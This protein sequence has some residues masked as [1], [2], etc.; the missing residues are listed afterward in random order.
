[1][2]RKFAVYLFVGTI[3]ATSTAGAI[4]VCGQT[5]AYRL[6]NNPPGILSGQ[7]MPAGGIPPGLHT[8]TTTLGMQ[9]CQ[10]SQ[11]QALPFNPTP[12]CQAANTTMLSF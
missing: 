9:A 6:S 5:G 4:R 11:W 3:L 2:K 1:M 8:P 10:P 12:I 7:P